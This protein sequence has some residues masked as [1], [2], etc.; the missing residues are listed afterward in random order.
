MNKLY[1][2]K[3]RDKWDIIAGRNY[4]VLK[5][6]YK[7]IRN[8][9]ILPLKELKSSPVIAGT[10]FEG[11]VLSENREFVSGHKR[12]DM[13]IFHF[14]MN[15]GYEFNI[16]PIIDDR[17]VIYGGII[18]DVFGHC[19]TETLCRL[20]YLLEC[21]EDIPIVF[22]S[23][24]LKY[25][26]PQYFYAMMEL[27]GIDKK[28]IIILKEI[29]QYREIIIPDQALVMFQ[30][31]NS[32]LSNV[33][34][35]IVQNAMKKYSGKI[36]KKVYLSRNKFDRGDCINEKW[37]EHFYAERGFEIIY[38]ETMTL[39]EQVAIVSQADQIVCTGGTLSHLLLFA[40]A[41]CYATIMLRCNEPAALTAQFI[42]NQMKK[43]YVNWVDVSYNILPTTHAS[44]IFYVRP[45]DDF[46]S[47]LNNEN[48]PYFEEELYSD[49]DKDLYTYIQTYINW[50]ARNAYAYKRLKSLDFFSVINNMSEVINGKTLTR[51]QMET[52]DRNTQI[53]ELLNK[54]DKIETQNLIYKRELALVHKEM[55]FNS[56]LREEDLS[57]IDSKLM[58]PFVTWKMHVAYRGWLDSL[59][60]DMDVK[61]Q[62]YSGN[63]LEALTISLINGNNLNI[64]YRVCTAKNGWEPEVEMGNVAGSVGKSNAILAVQ[65]NL[66][67]HTKYDVL[68]RVG[69]SNEWSKWYKGGEKTDYKQFPQLERIEL[70]LEEI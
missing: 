52:P 64:R 60:E 23:K 48:I 21:G 5:C 24:N 70:K 40:S 20:W 19:I 26:V 63:R 43:I 13:K 30:G 11:G 46:V 10:P 49:S 9:Y 33:Y 31:F 55:T 54:V 22:L 62:E 38:P 37:F 68:Y 47:Y 3:N 51:I 65:I 12:N 59:V 35:A 18:F 56:E 25:I 69:Y 17:C 4:D 44:G 58:V 57:K 39:V 2:T 61:A 7:T 53:R 28:R 42:I 14:A 6:G 27:L 34:K 16:R 1:I 15:Q 32:K 67:D 66:S 50:Y 45:T 8:G 29:T 36:F 41:E